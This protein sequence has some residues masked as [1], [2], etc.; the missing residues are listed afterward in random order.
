MNEFRVGRD[1]NNST[2][3]DYSPG[4]VAGDYVN[5]WINVVD[6]DGNNTEVD[7]RKSKP[8]AVDSRKAKWVALII[9]LLSLLL[10]LLTVFVPMPIWKPA[11]V[12]FDSGFDITQLWAV[13][14]ELLSGRI[15][16][17]VAFIVLVILVVLSWKY[18][19]RR[20]LSLPKISRRF[21]LWRSLIPIDPD[22]GTYIRAK[23]YALCIE[24]R[25]NNRTV[26]AKIR[27]AGFGRN[28]HYFYK[29][30]NKHLSGFRTESIMVDVANAQQ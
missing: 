25:A 7:L 5:T 30:R 2:S 21:S 4:T 27:A 20:S 9:S 14:T 16:F 28:K 10:G 23:P 17:V 18:W 26:F 24:C 3:G 11:Q 15:W 13:F 29:C 6:S 19:R 12:W 8:S 1:S 22:S